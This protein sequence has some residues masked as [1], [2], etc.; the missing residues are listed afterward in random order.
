MIQEEVNDYTQDSLIEKC[1]DTL[2]K[3]EQKI[4]IAALVNGFGS[5]SILFAHLWLSRQPLEEDKNLSEEEDDKDFFCEVSYHETV[6]DVLGYVTVDKL[7]AFEWFMERT[8]GATVHFSE[9]NA[10]A[11]QGSLTENLIKAGESEQVEFKEGACFSPMS[12][13]K[14]SHMIN[15]IARTV[16]AFMNSKGG[17]IFIGICDD[18]SIVGVQREYNIANPQKRNKDGYLLYL[19]DALKSRI[20]HGLIHLVGVRIHEIQGQDICEIKVP[21]TNEFAY[22]QGKV[23]VRQGNRSLELTGKQLVEHTRSVGSSFAS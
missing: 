12:G 14:D 17:R 10:Y 1:V 16:A 19:L 11:F 20:D 4:V 23:Y 2:V 3:A 22:F 6:D 21:P 15:G 9:K 8:S 7:R 18:S 5:E 13:K